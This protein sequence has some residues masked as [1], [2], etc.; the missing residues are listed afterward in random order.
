MS[1]DVRANLGPGIAIL[2]DWY[3]NCLPKRFLAA[4]YQHLVLLEGLA[5]A[6]SD[7][8]HRTLSRTPIATV[9]ST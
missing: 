2:G 9:A 4:I 5:D 3:T 8:V 6:T 7:G 1:Q